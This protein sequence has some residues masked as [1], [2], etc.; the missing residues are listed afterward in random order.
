MDA[1]RYHATS[2]GVAGDNAAIAYSVQLEV[3]GPNGE[4]TQA[5]VIVTRDRGATWTPAPFVR[6]IA[7]NLRFWGFPVWPPEAID[8]IEF[9]DGSLRIRF[10]DEW[11]MFEPGGESMWTGRR[12]PGDLWTVA[13]VRLMDYDNAD[14]ATTAPPIDV[15]LPAEIS[16][17]P[18]TVVDALASRIA[19]SVPP[20]GI[21]HYAWLIA[22]PCAAPFAVWG[23]SWRSIAA[24]I[25]MVTAIPIVNILIARRHARRVCNGQP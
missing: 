22:I 17:P 13:R 21:D 8:E 10:R 9:D 11:M 15:S 3:R 20:R 7:S 4:S 2:Q 14:K 19:R 6:T 1:P 18:P 12:L 25:A 5:F 23:P 16:P 24:A